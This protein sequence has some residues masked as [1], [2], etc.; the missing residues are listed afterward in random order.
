MPE[1]TQSDALVATQQDTFD[2]NDFRQRMISKGYNS[3]VID[4]EIKRRLAPQQVPQ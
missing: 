2:P 4:S 1:L 3:S